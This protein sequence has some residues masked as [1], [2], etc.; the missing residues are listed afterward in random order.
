MERNRVSWIGHVAPM[1]GI[2]EKRLHIQ[3]ENLTGDLT[4]YES[5]IYSTELAKLYSFRNVGS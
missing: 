3:V 2:R 4:V 1:E 5:K